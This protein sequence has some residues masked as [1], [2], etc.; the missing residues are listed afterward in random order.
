[1]FRFKCRPDG[2]E[3][4]EVIALSRAIAAWENAPGQPKGSRRSI[5]KL[6]ETTMGDMVD[7]AWFQASR[8]GRTGLDLPQWRDQVDVEMKEYKDDDEDADEEG[9]TSE[10]P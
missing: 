1:M 9:P 3:P 6:S 4:F 2:G 8:E 7:L 5:S 10:A